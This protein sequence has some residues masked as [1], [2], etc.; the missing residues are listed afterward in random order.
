[1]L[2][3]MFQTHLLP[4][5][6]MFDR[7]IAILKK[8]PLPT[9]KY[10]TTAGEGKSQAFGIVRQRNGSYTGSRLNFERLDVYSEILDLSKKI[11]PPEFSFQSIQVNQN[12]RSQ[13]HKDKGNLGVSAIVG[14]GDY[15][16]GALNI[17]GQDVDIR[18]K[19]IFFDGS[20]LL[21][22]TQAWEGDR[23]SLVFSRTQHSFTQTPE[24]RI[25]DEHLEEILDGVVIRY[26][27]KGVPIW[28]SNGVLPT[29]HIRTPTLRKC[30][31]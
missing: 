28:S 31:L 11:L 8:R 23:Y 17:D 3:E 15:V 6:T 7:L 16:G 10:R 24:F 22:F 4:Q 20:E 27:H 26:T 5:P 21:H 30:I 9:N 13:P 12:Y 19:L 2:R 18:H 25:V 14:F 29:R 1:M